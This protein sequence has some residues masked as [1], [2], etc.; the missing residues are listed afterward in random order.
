V[1]SD[2][3][4]VERVTS[5]ATERSHTIGMLRIKNEAR[6]IARV[7]ERLWI[8]C[9]RIVILD[10]GSTDR[11]WEVARTTL[12]ARI[13]ESGLRPGGWQAEGDAEDGQRHLV[14]LR[15]PFH[16]GTNPDVRV[17]ELRDKNYLW[18]A[19]K[20]W[21]RFDHVL[22]IDGDEILSRRLVASIPDAWVAFREPEGPDWFS[23]PF[24]YCWDREDQQRIDGIYGGPN[25][26][27]GKRLNFP[28]FFTTLHMSSQ[29]Y[30]ESRF[31]WAMMGGFH[32][33]SIPQE[34]FV[35]ADGSPP[36][37]AMLHGAMIHLGYLDQVERERKF[38]FYNRI[39]PGN[40]FEGYYKHII[41]EPDQHA[42]GPVELAP[43][44]DLP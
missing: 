27:A 31:D 33:G 35:R 19:V 24:V 23:I 14:V 36:R 5:L 2:T 20:S 6:W 32:C 16:P 25:P 34:G 22:C 17:N 13:R 3:V 43:F 15:S 26:H 7:L 39:D 8:V 41:G 10:D 11:T 37:K 44:E 12:G 4:E 30:F 38:E 42:P 21:F 1:S 18:Y 40:E 29:S 9:R 28:R